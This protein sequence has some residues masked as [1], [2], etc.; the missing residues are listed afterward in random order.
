[1][2]ELNLYLVEERSESDL[3]AKT[4]SRWNRKPEKIRKGNISYV[5]EGKE[6]TGS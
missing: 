4:V 2:R 1:M 5:N 3:G 6:S